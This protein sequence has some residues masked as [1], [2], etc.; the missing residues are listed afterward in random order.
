MGPAEE[1][2]CQL[3]RKHTRVSIAPS[4]RHTRV[5]VRVVLEPVPGLAVLCGVVEKGPRVACRVQVWERN[6]ESIRDPRWRIHSQAGPNDQLLPSGSLGSDCDRA[7]VKAT[8]RSVCSVSLLSFEKRG[9][10][11]RDVTICQVFTHQ[12]HMTV[13]SAYQQRQKVVAALGGVLPACLILRGR[14]VTWLRQ[15]SFCAG[16][17]YSQ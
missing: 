13:K 12:Q 6:R 3:C 16:E 10:A 15:W 2:R 11:T 9:S 14:I 4:R 8:S 5:A 7:S 1:E 17:I